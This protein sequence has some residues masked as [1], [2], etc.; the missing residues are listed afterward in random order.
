VFLC[1]GPL[2]RFG[3]TAANAGALALLEDV[4]VNVGVKTACAS[5]S[6]GLFRIL[7]MPVDAVKT[8]LQVEGKHGLTHLKTKI[9]SNGPRVLFNGSL[10]ASG[11]TIVGHFPWFFTFNTL[12]EKVRSSSR[13]LQ[14]QLFEYE[15]DGM[16]EMCFG[17]TLQIPKA[18]TFLGNLGRTAFMGFC[19]SVVSDTVSNSIRVIKTT[20]QTHQQ[21]ITYPEAVKEIVAKDGVIGLFGRGLQTRILTNG[22]QV[23]VS[24]SWLCDLR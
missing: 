13:V 12:N 1:Q 5:V 14:R 17:G 16:G 7:L 11:A 4:D 2:S 9:A 10:A 18:E 23:R 22:L 24:S 21:H 8:S 19:S 3:D 6:A 15:C 20:K